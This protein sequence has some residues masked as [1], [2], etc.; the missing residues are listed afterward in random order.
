MKQLLPALCFG[1]IL[2][3]CKQ[4]PTP[5][6]TEQPLVTSPVAPEDAYGQLFEAVQLNAVFPDSKTF[7]DCTARKTPKE[8]LARYQ[9]S[10]EKPGFKLADFVE[11]YFEK[12]RQYASSFQS[13]PSRTPAAHINALW[14]ILTRQADA[15]TAGSTL[16]ALPKS[17]IVPGGRFGEIYY[18]DSYFTILGLQAAGRSDMI[19]NMAD[20]FAYLIDMWIRA[21]AGVSIGCSI[22]VSLVPS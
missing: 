2:T 5:P 22:C 17:Y 8:I 14:P 4:N 19:G 12:P 13:D 7:V 18:W 6:A 16:L 3:A 9:E 10:K 21:A 20:N 11:E 1:L 15:S